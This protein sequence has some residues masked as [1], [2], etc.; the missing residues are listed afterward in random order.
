[1]RFD[2]TIFLSFNIIPLILKIT[3]FPKIRTELL[4]LLQLQFL[5]K[6]PILIQDY[7]TVLW[8][9]E[10]FMKYFSGY[11]REKSNVYNN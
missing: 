6:G 11:A 5:G 3:I 1:L 2:S 10:I 9:P 7:L 8:N 4:P